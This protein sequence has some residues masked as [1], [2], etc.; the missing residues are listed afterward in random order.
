MESWDNEAF[1]TLYTSKDKPW[2]IPASSETGRRTLQ[3]LANRLQLRFP[4]EFV[5]EKNETLSEEYPMLVRL[6]KDER[7]GFI[8]TMKH[9]AK[10]G[11]R[12]RLDY[13][14]RFLIE[15]KMIET[16][17]PGLMFQ[18]DKIKR[19]A[20]AEIGYQIKEPYF[21]GGD[22]PY[23]GRVYPYPVF[24][25]TDSMDL[26]FIHGVL[27][28]FYQQELLAR[29]YPDYGVGGELYELN[30]LRA[31]PTSPMGPNAQSDRKSV[32]QDAAIIAAE[33]KLNYGRRWAHLASSI[34]DEFANLIKAHG[35]DLFLA[36][37]KE[38]SDRDLVEKV[39]SIVSKLPLQEGKGFCPPILHDIYEA[40]NKLYVFYHHG[41]M[42]TIEEINRLAIGATL[43]GEW[44]G[45][46]GKIR[47][48]TGPRVAFL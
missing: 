6:K 23:F 15:A 42:M 16:A 48:E 22:T 4:V 21:P 25:V 9:H 2:Q 13:G 11:E 19:D 44:G 26:I 27:V 32:I 41:K 28:S 12:T 31:L 20:F 45:V 29:M 7:S 3:D 46:R 38:R 47:M 17:F 40:L 14:V 35:S 1:K 36:V 5:F 43:K 30:L 34:S 39:H 24:Q 18:G 37:L 10:Y 33:S 8:L